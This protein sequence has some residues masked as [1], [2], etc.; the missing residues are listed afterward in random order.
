MP[1][2]DSEPDDPHALVGV[3]VPADATATYDMAVA[4]ADEFARSGLERDRIL[5]LYRNP[6]YAGA[7]AALQA[8]G[9]GAIERIVDECL[10]VWGR[11]RIVTTD[12]AGESA[13]RDA[14][15][16]TGDEP[17]PRVDG[18]TFLRVI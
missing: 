4:F 7:H 6:F 8:L 14:G 15:G 17:R 3:S 1:Y 5:A 18:R 16:D 12:A 10:G 2:D 9:Q 11:V 13:G